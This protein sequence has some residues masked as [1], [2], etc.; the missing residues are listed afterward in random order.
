SSTHDEPQELR[1][2]GRPRVVYVGAIDQRL[3]IAAIQFLAKRFPG[4][5]FIIIGDGTRHEKM[6]AIAGDNVHVLG[7]VPH[8]QLSAYLQHCDVGILPL[9][10]SHS[11]DG[12]SPLKIYEYGMSGLSVLASR[13]P[14]LDRR[15]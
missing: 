8:A 13:T 2:I 4:V 10:K 12:R 9:I 15:K 7:L 5:S 11:N 14:E 3:D 1:D 6:E